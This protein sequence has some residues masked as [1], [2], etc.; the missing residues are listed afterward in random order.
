MPQSYKLFGLCFQQYKVSFFVSFYLILI[1]LQNPGMAQENLIYNGDFELFSSCPT[2]FSD[3]I[4]SPEE[5]EKCLGWKTPTYGSADFFN[6]CG[7]NSIVQ[8]PANFFGNQSPFNGDGYLGGY[9]ACYKSSGGSDGYTGSLWWEYIQGQL[10]TTLEAGKIYRLSME[11]SLAE[12][13]DLMITE[14]GAYFSDSPITSLNSKPL[15]VI[16]QCVFTEANYYSNTV[17]WMHLETLYKA[18]GTEKYITIGNFQD[19][20]STDTLRRYNIDYFNNPF[21]SYFYI[22]NVQLIDPGQD[23]V[24]ANVFTPNGDGINDC[25]I[26]P[27]VD[28]K[29]SKTVTIMN[30]WG[31]LIKKGD[32]NGFQWNGKTP[33]GKECSEGTYFFKISD[34]NI[35]GFIQLAM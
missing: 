29:N 8:V 9:F 5:I 34:T 15:E 10:V 31:E 2:Q 12:M 20:I 3:P 18:S 33:D 17:D 23:I 16:P 27:Y 26:L 28:K 13:S 35:A 32:L 6:S 7:T 30:R 25:W 4:Q 22:D 19:S 1:S 11:L 14:I 24:P 21:M